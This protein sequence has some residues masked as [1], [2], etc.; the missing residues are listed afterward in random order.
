[1]T[2]ITPTD[3][4][5]TALTSLESL[6]AWC[7]LALNRINPDGEAIEEP[8]VTVKTAQVGLI[9]D[10]FGNPRLI[11]R[12]SIQLSPDYASDTSSKLW[13]KAEDLGNV[14]LPSTYT[15]D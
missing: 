5:P 6:T 12:A 1:M 13:A 3:I 11:G 7:L 4:P 8:G 9:I 2:A 15:T 14:A 10:N